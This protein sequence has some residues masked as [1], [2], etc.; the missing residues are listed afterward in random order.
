MRD[1]TLIG[2]VQDV[3]GSTVSVEIDPT[4]PTGLV[5]VRGEPHSVG[6]VGGFARVPLGFLDL[7]GV[8]TRVGAGAA[9]SNTTAES[10]TQTRWLSL[11]LVGEAQNG[12]LFS[13]GVSQ[14]PNVGD[15]VHLVT[16]ADLAKIYGAADPADGYIEIGKVA[17]A[18]SISARVNLNQLVTRHSAVVGSTGSGKSTT[19]A[20][21]VQ[22]I[23]ER[24]A[25]PSARVVLFDIHGEY[26]RSFGAA[27]N[28]FTMNIDA[29]KGSLGLNVPYWALSFDELVPLIFGSLLDDSGRAF[30]RDEIVRL[31]RASLSLYPVAGLAEAEVT[32]DSPIAFSLRQLWFDMHVLL[33]ATHTVAGTGQSRDTWA[34]ELDS[35]GGPLFEGDAQNLLPPT[36]VP[37]SQAAGAPKVFLSAAPLNIRRQVDVLA[38]RLR[39][40]RF[41]FLLD[42]GPWSPSLDGRTDADLDKLLEQW[43]GYPQAITIVDLSGVP[44][45]VIGDLVG[46]MTRVIYDAMFWARLLSE[47]ARERPLLLIF[48][49]AHSYLGSGESA[50]K[51]AVQ[52]VV[53]EG[54]KYGMGAMLV[55]QR[56]S[57]LDSTILSQCGT[58]VAMRLT[59]S[60]DRQHVGAA[61]AD[62]MNGILGMLPILRTGEAIVIGESVPIPMRTLITRPLISPDSLD[63]VLVGGK[64]AGGWDRQRETSDYSGVVLAWR[65]QS[66]YSK[67]LIR[68]QS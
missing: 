26:A 16:N 28:V 45:T 57:E 11:Q 54:R 39:D 20:A 65:S 23:A 25:F 13:R 61:A 64:E 3:D 44:P 55:S 56:P 67:R 6:Q 24:T 33:N 51:Q 29:V 35:A 46:A 50:A 36:F 43:L 41:D 53:R 15:K 7:V 14:L 47:G 19:V 58:L 8:V 21:L 4:I 5:F 40:R 27:A 66:P 34:L 18:D 59:N 68:D 1:A 48:E 12:E 2:V 22:A 49:E 30:V 63:P 38:S 31:K 60:T 62:N 37:Q 52:R 9:P 10:A 17:S 32:V 42:P